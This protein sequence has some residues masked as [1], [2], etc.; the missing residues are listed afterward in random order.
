[1]S[2]TDTTTTEEQDENNP[3]KLNRFELPNRLVKDEDTA[4]DTYARF[5]AEPF[6]QGFGHTIGNSLRRVLLSSL[7]GAAITSVRIAYFKPASSMH[8]SCRSR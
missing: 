8:P 6:E 7:E 1:M 5:T 3:V 2:D 4:T